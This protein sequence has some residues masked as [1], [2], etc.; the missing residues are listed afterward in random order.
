MSRCDQFHRLPGHLL[1]V[2]SLDI[3]IVVMRGGDLSNMA[4][5]CGGVTP[6]SAAIVAPSF[7]DPRAVHF[8]KPGLIAPFPHSVAEAI[9]RERLAMRSH[10]KREV[11]IAEL[12]EGS[13]PA[14]R[15]RKDQSGG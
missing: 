13:N 7:L 8:R 11:R 6:F 5:I 12:S 9:A 10:E 1:P 2:R 15:M 4:I 14:T 3:C